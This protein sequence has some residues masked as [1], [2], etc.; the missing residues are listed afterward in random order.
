MME[1]FGVNNFNDLETQKKVFLDFVNSQTEE[2]QIALRK[3]LD[4]AW[5][6]HQGQF[7]DEGPLYVIHPIRMANILIK[8]LEINNPD[9]LI[10]ALL[11]DVVEDGEIRLDEI[12]KE[13]G[14]KIFKLVKNLTRERPLNET[15]E[16][17]RINKKKKFE[18]LMTADLDTRLVKTADLLD[19]V[20]SWPFIPKEHKSKL[21]FPR[22]FKEAE[23]YYLPM[24]KKTDKRLYHAL[25]LAFDFVKEKNK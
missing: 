18:K 4:V 19:N 14:T 24:A 20:R 16:E 12:N 17:K 3:A 1:T 23:N 6:N 25:K 9:L 15:E 22:W 13:F 11:H 10:A 2:S 7:R 21:K 5:E 8:E